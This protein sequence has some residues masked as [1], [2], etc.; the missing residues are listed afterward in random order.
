M[1]VAARLRIDVGG[2]ELSDDDKV[3]PAQ[4]LVRELRGLD[5]V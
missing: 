1:A 4:A 3:T 5:G 2:D